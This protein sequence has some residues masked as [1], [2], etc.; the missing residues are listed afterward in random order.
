[1]N[2]EDIKMKCFVAL[3]ESAK[4]FARVMN[5]RESAEIK[6]AV[7]EII[8]E[9][10]KSNIDKILALQISISNNETY[11]KKVRLENERIKDQLALAKSKE[12]FFASKC[13]LRRQLDFAHA[14][15]KKFQEADQHDAIF[16][17]RLKF[18]LIDRLGTGDYLQMMAEIN[19]ETDEKV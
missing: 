16:K 15:I 13:E 4:A 3:C 7:F 1:M 12:N 10:A 5:S 11:L 14:K 2:K 9:K 8:E 6:K 19:R 18:L 17:R